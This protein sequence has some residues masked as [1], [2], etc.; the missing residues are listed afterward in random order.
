MRFNSSCA[1]L[2]IQLVSRPTGQ[3]SDWAT[4][5]Q[6]GL[7]GPRPLASLEAP[8]TDANRHPSDLPHDYP[9]EPNSFGISN[10]PTPPANRYF[11]SE[12][13]AIWMFSRIFSLEASGLSP[14]SGNSQTIL[15]NF[16]KLNFKG[17]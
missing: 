2:A 7:R 1:T 10:G 5:F 4:L 13:Q 12:Y 11:C 14:N 15:C 8:R 3:P 16:G 17:S 9:S 6:V